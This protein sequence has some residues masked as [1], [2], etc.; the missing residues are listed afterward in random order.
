MSDHDAKEF[1]FMQSES[2]KNLYLKFIWLL[3]NKFHR[4]IY[5]V[6]ST[7]IFLNYSTYI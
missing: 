6:V 3:L 2:S 5:F 7:K 1:L 4:K